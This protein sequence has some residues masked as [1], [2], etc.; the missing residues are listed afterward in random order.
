MNACDILAILGLCP[1]TDM[2]ESHSS[3]DS[4]GTIAKPAEF[5]PGIARI[6]SSSCP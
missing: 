2:V 6:F 1:S 3:P 4:I 5:T